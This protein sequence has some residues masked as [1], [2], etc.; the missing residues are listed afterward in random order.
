MDL[1]FDQ[2]LLASLK[3]HYMPLDSP[4]PP[5]KSQKKFESDH[6]SRPNYQFTGN[7]RQGNTLTTVMMQSDLETVR[8]MT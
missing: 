4:T 2:Q 7:W 5:V 8:L 1:D 3:R 6:I